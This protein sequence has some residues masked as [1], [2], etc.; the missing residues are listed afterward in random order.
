[1]ITQRPPNVPFRPERIEIVSGGISMP[2]AG[3]AVDDWATP[4]FL[5]REYMADMDWIVGP[6][7][8]IHHWNGITGAY[9]VQR[10][11]RVTRRHTA[12]AIRQRARDHRRRL[13]DETAGIGAK[14][15]RRGIAKPRV[16]RRDTIRETVA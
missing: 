13:G 6:L 2:P 15:L 7:T 4:S 11:A 14:A 1:V 12:R 16:R 3:A 8:E 9:T 10:V 5:R